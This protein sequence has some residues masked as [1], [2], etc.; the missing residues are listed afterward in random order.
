MAS[1]RGLAIGDQDPPEDTR[2]QCLDIDL[3]LVRRDLEEVLALG[4]ALSHG[5]S[6]AETTSSPAESPSGGMTTSISALTTVHS[7]P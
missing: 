6:Q 3:D 4:D 5:L 2:V 7:L 1:I